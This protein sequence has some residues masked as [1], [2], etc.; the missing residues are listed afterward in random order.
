[1]IHELKIW[2][3]PFEEIRIGAKTFEVRQERSV[4]TDCGEI[5]RVVLAAQQLRSPDELR[6][7]PDHGVGILRAQAEIRQ[8]GISS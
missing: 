2:P 1:M 4:S 5:H 6:D 7:L 3:M 8:K